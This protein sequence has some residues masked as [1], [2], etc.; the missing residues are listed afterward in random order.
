MFDKRQAFKQTLPFHRR[1]FPSGLLLWLAI[2]A[3]C[4]LVG[5]AT[6]VDRAFPIKPWELNQDQPTAATKSLSAP[7]PCLS[8]APFRR[9]GHTPMDPTL[10]LTDEQLLEDLRLMAQWTGCIRTYG[11]S[12]GQARIP[13]LAETVGL[14][15]VLGAWV[16]RDRAASRQEVDTALA[17]AQAHPRTVRMV[18]VGNE[19]LLRQEQSPQELAALLRDA[20]QRSPVPV[21][22]ADVWEFW[23]RHAPVLEP[24]VDVVA[25]HLLPYWEDVPIGLEEAV[26]HVVSIHRQMTAAFGDKPVWIAETGWPSAG[27]QRGPA[28]PGPVEQAAFLRELRDR[29]QAEGIDFNLIEAFDQPWKRQFEG[30]MGAAW[31]VADASGRLRDRGQGPWPVDPLA[32]HGL[33]GALIGLLMGV[34]A[35]LF[36]G[37]SRG[38][39]DLPLHHPLPH[40]HAWVEPS[41][42]ILAGVTMG[43]LLAIH[44]AESPIWLRST[45]EW[46]FSMLHFLVAGLVC[47][48]G[49]A[50]LRPSSR[51]LPHVDGSGS[52]FLSVLVFA[53]LFITAWQ[54]LTLIAD[55]RYRPLHA[56]LAAAPAVGLWLMRVQCG[57]HPVGRGE[58]LLLLVIAVSAP[59][60]L[61]MEGWR[62]SQALALAVAWLLTVAALWPG[63]QPRGHHRD[64]V[65]HADSSSRAVCDAASAH[66][67]AAKAE[68][69]AS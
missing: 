42:M 16:S 69:S 53:L 46:M 7:F 2:W 5:I 65:A 19:V 39:S 29:L 51:S 68:R 58:S 27:R 26:S 37:A 6:L 62:N 38:R 4:L 66:S 33:W 34:A 57:A 54:A 47:V 60:L 45:G 13:A 55:G 32:R 11:T 31:G 44:A 23:L 30:A 10:R 17:L 24:E 28:R 36:G 41:M 12:H 35:Y 64:S 61:V 20:R 3:A 56:F 67:K 14:Q 50:R 18:I 21:A 48:A 1:A 40:A 52:A 25:A 43:T 49:L 8:Y 9:S 59:V 22:Y 15:V 63:R